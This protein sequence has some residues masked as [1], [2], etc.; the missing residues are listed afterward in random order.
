M[1]TQFRQHWLATLVLL[2]LALGVMLSFLGNT[3]GHV[4]VGPIIHH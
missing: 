3:G 1:L 4:T 2:L